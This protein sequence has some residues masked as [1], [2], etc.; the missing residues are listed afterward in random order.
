VGRGWGGLGMIGMNSSDVREV[1][2]QPPILVENP[3]IDQK[4]MPMY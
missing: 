3:I 2:E 1:M 4:Q